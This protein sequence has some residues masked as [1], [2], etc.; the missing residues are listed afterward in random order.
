[1]GKR[2]TGTTV[3]FWADPKYFDT[4]KYNVRALRHL[5]RAKAVLCPGL[6][7]TLFEEA[8][9]RRTSGSTR[10]ACAIT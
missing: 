5:L 7:V 4:P 1:V 10:T 6:K 3:R 9:A 8:T 2:N